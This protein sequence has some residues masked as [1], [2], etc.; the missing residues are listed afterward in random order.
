M[1]ILNSLKTKMLMDGREVDLSRNECAGYLVVYRRKKDAQA[2]ADELGCGI[3][4]INFDS[5]MQTVKG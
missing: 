1:W 3:T 5:A 2:D 4:E